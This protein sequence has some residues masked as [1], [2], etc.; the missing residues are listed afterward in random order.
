MIERSSWQLLEFLYLL[1]RMELKARYKGRFLGYLTAV[2][3]IFA[4][5]FVF[6]IAFKVI[7]G[8]DIQNYSVY[9]VAGLFPFAWL[10]M[11]VVSASRSFVAN[12][13]LIREMGLAH[14]I[15][16]LSNVVQEMMH[17]ALALPLIVAWVAIPGDYPPSWSWLWQIPLLMALQLVF[18]YPLALA[19]ALANAYVRDIE[20]WLGIG[21]VLLFFA[22]PMVYP[23]E[24]VPE[25]LARYFELNP[26]HALMAC[27]R[28]VFIESR[29]DATHAAVAAAFAAVEGIVVW[30]LY[31]RL[32]PR[33]GEVV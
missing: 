5:A 31:R 3:M 25:A 10:S 9:L 12:A 27:W 26:F 16:P 21:F 28:G 18:T 15:L 14:A 24:M 11:G 33:V 2:G 13:S 8:I 20:Y 4:L 1:A 30:L 7:M 19:A 29:L 6:W 32:A 23:I 22:T 17:F